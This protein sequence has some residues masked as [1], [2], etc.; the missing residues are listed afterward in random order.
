MK[1][2]LGRLGLGLFVSLIFT[3]TGHA[4]FTYTTNADN[5]LTITDYTG[6]SASV[7]IPSSN[8][9]KTVTRLGDESFRES[10]YMTSVS[11]P[12]GIT[13]IGNRA[14][15]LC[16]NL[17]GVVIPNNVSQLGGEAFSECYRLSSLTLGNGMK[18]IGESSF[19]NCTNLLNA[20]VP[21]A[22]TNIGDSAFSG[23]ASMTD[24]AIGIGLKNINRFA[25]KGCSAL[26]NV[27]IPN[28]V[29]NIGTEAFSYCDS[30]RNVSIGSGV[31]M[32]ENYA[33]FDCGSL[34]NASIGGAVSKIG[35]SAFAS[36]ALIGVTIPG[37]VT[38]IDGMAFADCTYLKNVVIP[39]NV[40]TLGF[41]AFQRCTGLTNLS[42]GAGIAVITN[43]VFESCS[44]LKN[45]TIP[46]G[47]RYIDQGAF[48]SCS[49]LTNVSVGTGVTNIGMSAF[50][51]CAPL[52]GVYFSGNAPSAGANLFD[53][54]TNIVYRLASATGWPTVPNTW[55]G[56]PTALWSTTTLSINP[57]S[58]NLSNAAASGKTID[59]TANVA[60]TAV[61]NVSWIAITAGASGS[62]NG[63][64][65]FSA[66]TNSGTTARTGGV[67]VAGG[68]LSQTCVVTQ[69]ASPASL[70]INPTI[71]NLT[72]AA[73]SGRTIAVTGNVSWTAATN[74]SW[75]AVTSGG[76]GT[77]NGA[78][79]FSVATNSATS[80]TGRIVVA[81]GGISLTCTVIQA[82]VSVPSAPTGVTASEN[83]SNHIRISWTDTPT[84]T[85]YEVWR[86]TNNAS[87]SATMIGSGIASS[88]FDD[89][90][91]PQ[92][93]AHYYWVKATNGGGA[94]VF[95]DSALGLRTTNMF[96]ISGLVSYGGSQTGAIH[97][98]AS[99]YSIAQ[100]NIALS[101]DGVDDGVSI[102]SPTAS[103]QLGTNITMCAWINVTGQLAGEYATVLVK[104]QADPSPLSYIMA[105]K[106][107]DGKPC[108]LYGD[109]HDYFA[110]QGI[111]TS[112]GWT[113]LAF[114]HNGTN[115]VWYINGQV[116]ST[117]SNP[118]IHRYGNGPLVIGRYVQTQNWFNCFP[119]QLDDIGLWSRT[120]SQGEIQNV[121]NNGMAGTEPGLVSC[122]DFDDGTANDITMTGNN[123]LFLDGATATN[124]IVTG[125]SY[126]ETNSSGGSYSISNVL[127][128]EYTISAFRDSDGD[129]IMD[130]WE[131]CGAYLANP[132]SVTGNMDNIDI[133]LQ[134]PT[135]DTDGDGLTDYD[136]TYLYGTLWD[137]PD[138]DGDGM[139]DGDEVLAGSQPTNPASVWG[140]AIP[141]F[142]GT[143]HTNVTWEDGAW[144][145]STWLHAE[146]CALS[147]ATLT[148]RTYRLYGAT[149]VQGPWES[150][151]PPISGTGSNVSYTTE[152]IDPLKWFFR[153]G[154][155]RE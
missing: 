23:C 136:E 38:S 68:G 117:T 93:I 130:S 124:R 99:P 91:V 98:T 139:P 25:F 107:S 133:S 5:T 49:S 60:W 115:G 153:V 105:L 100:T 145:T 81:G 24:L 79:V 108:V 66:T 90:T 2:M 87:G 88:P 40:T 122:W 15:Y 96:A 12:D 61:S 14:F 55:A 150:N 97:I 62:S 67:V 125:P 19:H 3:A 75:L 140:I 20:V 13:N 26:K 4:Q 21:D 48:S 80:R 30:L 118:P 73:W 36:T 33:F 52:R 39:D 137:D 56:R 16:T 54:C 85:G 84:A 18:S 29:T 65:T 70:T 152:D 154:V 89:S 149:N 86:N 147:W 64:V 57:T 82:G 58:T 155:G 34:T 71:T 59:I 37:S 69:A 143:W 51:G 50:S 112:N 9:G 148:G 72:S 138:S 101:L 28:N 126:S 128:G 41:Q 111:G 106:A 120:L 95:S 77:G 11:I 45:V 92:G 46:D 43:M 31:K 102:Q 27:S 32:I 109:G 1:S 63:T 134:D 17:T 113:H 22:T 103:L 151:S 6:G 129:G 123:G 121:M 119:G 142:E 110:S 146:R 47:I 94:S 135:T 114:T 74:V 35:I 83:F 141:T 53:G 10:Y 8:G 144:V 78:V 42:I 132:L 127:T 7:S 76:T 44:S 131:A 116:S 104:L